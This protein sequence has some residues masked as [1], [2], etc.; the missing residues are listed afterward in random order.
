MILTILIS[1]EQYPFCDLEIKKESLNYKKSQLSTY[2]NLL[3]T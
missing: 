1:L 2:G 3:D